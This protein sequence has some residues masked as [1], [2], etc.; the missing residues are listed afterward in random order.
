[1]WNALHLAGPSI[2][3]QKRRLF[4]ADVCVGSDE[5]V[6]VRRYNGL[7]RRQPLH[8]AFRR[9]TFLTT[10]LVLEERPAFVVP[11][12]SGFE[13][14]LQIIDLIFVFCHAHSQGQKAH[15]PN[16]ISSNSITP[17]TKFIVGR[18]WLQNTKT[19][20]PSPTG[21]GRCIQFGSASS[22]SHWLSPEECE[23]IF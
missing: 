10:V 3:A 16:R 13:P 22:E 4:I 2:D 11:I 1:M 12:H 14:R 9:W 20:C 18:S 17:E 5:D 21:Q 23:F 6:P 7:L 8:S 15:D 19:D